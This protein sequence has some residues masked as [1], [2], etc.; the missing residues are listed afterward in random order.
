MSDTTNEN[1]RTLYNNNITNFILRIDFEHRFRYDIEDVVKTIQ[2]RFDKTEKRFSHQK[3]NFTKQEVNYSATFEDIASTVLYNEAS[4]G[5]LTFS[6]E[7]PSIVF[8]TRRYVSKEVY[9]DLFQELSNYFSSNYPD[10]LTA[11]IGMRFIN[12]FPVKTDR[13]FSKYLKPLYSR[14]VRSISNN[15]RLCR[16]FIQQETVDDGNRIRVLYGL[17]NK[18][19]PSV[20]VSKDLTIDIDS[21]ID[22]GIL[23]KDWSETLKALNHAAYD[24][25]EEMV[26][27]KYIESLRKK[28]V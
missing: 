11:R 2:P 19:Y 20:I 28:N 17:I 27:P 25:F 15:E 6:P 7:P 4:K 10:D 5:S 18:Y 8:E 23:F 26:N 16:T 24:T 13:D 14:L 21:F 1:I 9:E 22:G 3:I 12:T